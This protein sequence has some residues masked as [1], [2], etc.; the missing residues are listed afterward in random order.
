[1][2]QWIRTSTQ[3]DAPVP[4]PD[5]ILEGKHVHRWVRKY[6][7]QGSI[8]SDGMR[9]VDLEGVECI[10]Y[11][12]YARRPLCQ[13][14]SEKRLRER[15]DAIPK[16]LPGSRVLRTHIIKRE[17]LYI[18]FTW[19]LEEMWEDLRECFREHGVADPR[20][21]WQKTSVP[22]PTGTQL[23]LLD[24]G[25]KVQP[26]ATFGFVSH[27]WTP[28]GL[29]RM[30]GGFARRICHPNHGGPGA[31]QV[32]HW[33]EAQGMRWL[34]GSRGDSLE[35]MGLEIKSSPLD[36]DV[37]FNLLDNL[38]TYRKNGLDDSRT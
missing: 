3:K 33:A 19:S 17:F 1:M 22:V 29:M 10:R 9:V 28:A 5:S 15:V 27:A 2:L 30:E 36:D 14:E 38:R 23:E 8:H 6:L 25:V 32:E 21:R 13:E 31:I 37:K 12:F 18:W 24:D 20:V 26:R 16:V 4:L 34:V 11:P 35:V 7:A